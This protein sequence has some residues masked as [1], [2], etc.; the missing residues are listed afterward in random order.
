MPPSLFGFISFLEQGF[1]NF[2]QASIELEI[3]LSQ[4]SK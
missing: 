4:P 1:T 2:A 3:F